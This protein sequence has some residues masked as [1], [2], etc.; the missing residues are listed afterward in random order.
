MAEALQRR[1][2]NGNGTQLQKDMGFVR[3]INTAAVAETL[4][5]GI[6]IPLFCICMYILVQNRRTTNWF[7]FI[8][9]I[10][11][12]GLSTA[13]VSVTL[14]LLTH[15]MF[16]LILDPSDLRPAQRWINT[17]T[18]IF[19][20]NNFVADLVLL[21]R[22]YMVWGKSKYILIGASILVLLDS[23]WGYLGIGKSLT[24]GGGPFVPLYIWSIFII[25]ILLTSV[26]VGRIV[27]VSR[28]ARRIIGHRQ[29]ASYR[30]A[31]AILV[32][33]SFIYSAVTLAY[34]LSPL[35]AP[36][37]VVLMTTSM[38]IVA[39]MPTLLIVQVGLGRVL[40]VRETKTTGIE[41]LDFSGHSTSVVLDTVSRTEHERS[42]FNSAV[43][44]S[45]DEMPS[46]Q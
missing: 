29:L 20:T 38:R 32:E 33:S 9:A 39:I 26:T 35:T 3:A 36:Y 34:A 18:P 24:S 1:A 23:V 14:R 2:A 37:R 31:I 19:V 16:S 8:S 46:R 10:L 21:Y 13:D 11:M 5:Y 40:V 12:F 41:T 15:D 28:V 6:H 45:A 17:K 22:C 43:G 42:T 27:W 25:N 44:A 7:I 4:L 30:A